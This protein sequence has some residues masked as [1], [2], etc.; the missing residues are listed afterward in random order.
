[1]EFIKMITVLM[2]TY[3]SAEYLSLSIESILKQ[4]YNYYELLIIDDGSTDESVKIIRQYRDRRINLVQ[5]EHTGLSDTL[6]Y[7]LKIAKYDLIARM[8]ADDISHP[9]RLEQQ[10]DYMTNNKTVNVLSCWY[11][12][13]NKNKI[14]YLIKNPEKHSNVVNG[15]PLYSY[16]V[17][18]GCIYKRNTILKY[19]GYEHSSFEDYALWLKMKDH[20]VFGNVPKALLYVRYRIN[21]LSRM[22]IE[23]K[24]R[25]QYKIQEKYYCNM[26]SSFNIYSK[27]KQFVLRGWREYFYGDSKLAR[28]YWREYPQLIFTDYRIILAYL[29]TYLPKKNFIR[30]KE[31]RL[32]YRIY[33][34]MTYFSSGNMENRCQFL[35]LIKNSDNINI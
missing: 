6:N 12:I 5:K 22:S 1:M 9:K 15:L 13:F 21:S 28:L 4:T 31:L 27:K 26:S 23:K 11:Y 33:Y 14:Q 2:P 25:D 34:I 17:H 3:N 7:G 32:R 18:S 16:I 30:F 35:K 24:Y 20:I 8:D 10:L 19:G 29:I